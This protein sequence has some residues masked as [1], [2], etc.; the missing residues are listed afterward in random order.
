MEL[1][2]LFAAPVLQIIL[3]LFRLT[4]KIRIPLVVIFVLS[5]FSGIVC[6]F[7]CMNIVLNELTATSPDR[8]VC[9]M[10]ALGAL[11]V[12]IFITVVSGSVI[13]VIS[14]LVDLYIQKMAKAKAPA[15]IPNNS[16]IL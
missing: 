13:A 8:G 4:G 15:I 1:L 6:S 7:I 2:L 11:V 16:T 5:L 14:A 9:G 10:P 3:S 12:G